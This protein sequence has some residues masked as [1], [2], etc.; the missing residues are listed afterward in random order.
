MKHRGDDMTKK[1]QNRIKRILYR[2]IKKSPAKE[3]I[4]KKLSE[5]EKGLSGTIGGIFRRRR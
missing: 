2:P 4:S 5:A 3:Y 1:F